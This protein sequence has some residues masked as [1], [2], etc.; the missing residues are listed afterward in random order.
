V[1]KNALCNSKIHHLNQV[2]LLTA[3]TTRRQTPNPPEIESQREGEMMTEG[4]WLAYA[5]HSKLF[6]CLRRHIPVDHR[7]Y[8]LF[9]SACCRTFL[10]VLLKSQVTRNLIEMAEGY[11]DGVAG[12]DEL[13]RAKRMSLRA[14]KN[15]LRLETAVR[16]VAH[17]LPHRQVVDFPFFC[18]RPWRASNYNRPT[19]A[20]QRRLVRIIRDIFGNPF[21]PINLDPA[22]LTSTVVAFARQMYDSRD[23]SAMP[24]LADALQD[25]GCENEEILKHCRGRGE[26]T[27]G[28]FVV[29][30]CLGRG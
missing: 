1:L 13:V 22:W 27:R 4:E 21:R 26:H 16:G 2:C 20:Q 18:L 24:I 9:L 28:C 7:K 12:R 3:V 30:A 15:N 6:Q 25:A 8:R 10:P 11:A 29:D 19:V 5:E 23:F 14:V 17:G